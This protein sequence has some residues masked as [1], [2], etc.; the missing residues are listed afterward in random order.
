MFVWRYHAGRV[1]HYIFQN[2][3]LFG[4]EKHVKGVMYTDLRIVT[5]FWDTKS[6]LRETNNL[7]CETNNFLQEVKNLLEETKILLRETMHTNFTYD[8]VIN[9]HIVKSVKSNLHFRSRLPFKQSTVKSLKF[10]DLEYH[11]EKL[12]IP[13]KFE[14]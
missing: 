11:Y 14:N 9:D 3:G 5:V 8:K 1:E 10:R 2:V 12:C 6:V 7:P 4:I 13:R